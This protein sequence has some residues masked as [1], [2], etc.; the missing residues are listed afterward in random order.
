M[1][2]KQ[3]FFLLE[4]HSQKYNTFK[5]IILQQQKINKIY[6]ILKILK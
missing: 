6:L 5:I 2:I 3:F 1:I 4:F